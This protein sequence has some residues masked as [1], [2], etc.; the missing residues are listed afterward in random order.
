MLKEKDWLPN[1]GS[2]RLLSNQQEA[3]DEANLI[4]LPNWLSNNKNFYWSNGM[5]SL[6]IETQEPRAQTITIN[7]DSISVDLKTLS[8]ISLT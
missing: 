6:A 4:K 1:F 8:S 3:L 2:T 5:N 7:E